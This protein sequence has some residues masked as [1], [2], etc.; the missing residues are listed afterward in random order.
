MKLVSKP[1]EGRNRWR[2]PDTDYSQR[3]RKRLIQYYHRINQPGWEFMGLPETLKG[4]R[5]GGCRF[6]AR[7]GN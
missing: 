7:G 3:Q 6:T 2:E 1:C 5:L 4:V